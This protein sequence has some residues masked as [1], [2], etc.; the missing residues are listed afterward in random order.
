MFYLLI[1]LRRT[2]RAREWF[3]RKAVPVPRLAELLDLVAVGTLADVVPLDRNNRILVSQG[4]ARI[5]AGRCRP[6]VAALLRVAGRDPART[7]ASDVGFA[8]APRLNAAGRLEDMS[9][10]IECLL[11]PTPALARERALR[12]D[13]LNRE[14]RGIEQSM[15]EQAMAH[16]RELA[17]A[18]SRELPLGL[19]LYDE[20]WHPGVV[21]ILASRI[22]DRYHRPVIA[23]ANDGERGLKGSARSVGGVHVRDVLEAVAAAHPDLLVRFGGH[24]M[25][26]GLSLERSR[27]DAFSCA[28]DAEVRRHLSASALRGATMSDGELAPEQLDLELAHRLRDGGPWG[29]GFPEPCFDGEFEVREARVVGERHVKL[30]LGPAGSG[31]R[32]D[33]IAFNAAPEWPAGLRRARLAYRLGVNFYQGLQSAQLVVEDWEKLD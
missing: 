5:R 32:V 1:A 13:E 12:L 28:F 7:T 18:E 23:F 3:E 29:Q 6:G 11:A 16:L 30:V 22:K 33:A 27:F 20:R 19:C 25:A 14:R 24:A 17:L 26:A 21:G 10:G 8:L 9:L 31:R 15:Q 4:L 2:L